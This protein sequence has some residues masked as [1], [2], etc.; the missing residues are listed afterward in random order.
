MALQPSPPQKLP[1]VTD[2]QVRALPQLGTVVRQGDSLLLSMP[3]AEQAFLRYVMVAIFRPLH[4][5]RRRFRAELDAAQV[6]L[7]GH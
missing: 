2:A 5:S 3:V 6:P 1:P 4:L 7:H